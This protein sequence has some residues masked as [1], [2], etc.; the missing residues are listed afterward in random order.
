MKRKILFVGGHTGGHLFPAE[1]IAQALIDIDGVTPVYLDHGRTMEEKVF[2]GAGM[3]KI[4][5]PWSGRGRLRKVLSVPSAIKLLRMEK[6][7][8]LVAMGASPCVAPGL[9]AWR[10]GIPLYLHEQNRV[11]GRA[12]RWLT[13]FASKVFLSF[14]MVTGGRVLRSKVAILGCPVRHQF[15]PQEPQLDRQRWLIM[16]GSQGADEVNRRILAAAQL[17]PP[18]CRD[19]VDILHQVGSA[20]ANEI[21]QAWK[22]LGFKAQVV[23]FI[24]SVAEAIAESH[25]VVC[26]SGGSTIAE[27]MAIGRPGLMFPYPGHRD[28]HQVI[29]AEYL[30][31]GGAGVIVR[32][33]DSA[34]EISQQLM[35][36][37]SSQDLL[38]EM[39]M[40]ARNLG[41]PRAAI[42]IAEM[43]TV[44]LD[45][46]EKGRF[47]TPMGKERNFRREVEIS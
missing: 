43:I 38:G 24:D 5:A 42:S 46:I 7:S 41:R 12:N 44:H 19:R 21:D 39:A 14:P 25:L 17:I 37:I 10:L 8:A 30:E 3:E 45:A 6:I 22:G 27:L 20:A 40:R 33:Q 32:P 28:E 11:M 9:A 34:A 15:Q 35:E 31:S 1:A 4:S 13:P 26:R 18:A 29:N 47:S 23:P 36:F 16:G 2:N